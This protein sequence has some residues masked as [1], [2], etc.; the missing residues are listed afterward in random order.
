MA[1]F[2]PVAD[3][4]LMGTLHVEAAMSSSVSAGHKFNPIANDAARRLDDRL[5]TSAVLHEEAELVRTL[6]EG[7]HTLDHLR[8][9]LRIA[10][11]HRKRVV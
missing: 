8:K 3:R 7:G 5:T 6:S 4:R 10:H 9:R 11:R 2:G 1:A